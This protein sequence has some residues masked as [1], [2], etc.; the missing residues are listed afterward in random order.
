MPHVIVYVSATILTVSGVYALFH[1]R[2]S[3][4]ALSIG[5]MVAAFASIPV[6]PVINQHVGY[7]SVC[8]SAMRLSQT[9]GGLPIVTWKMKNHED[10]DVYLGRV[11]EVIPDDATPA[12]CLAR[13]AVVIEPDKGKTGWKA[14][15][16]KKD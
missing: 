14:V 10:M 11:P 8:S 4:L 6:I 7:A 2:K 5:V 3:V 15:V 13:S 9:A 1:I 12:K 16:V